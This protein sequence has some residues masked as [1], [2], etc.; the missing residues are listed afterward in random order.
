MFCPYFVLMVTQRQP[1]E[2]TDASLRAAGCQ[3]SSASPHL[4]GGICGFP[5]E[6]NKRN[7]I[8][9]RETSGKSHHRALTE[10]AHGHWE[11]P[12]WLPC[13]LGSR[14]T[15]GMVL[16]GSS[17]EQ[18]GNLQFMFCSEALISH[19]DQLCGNENKRR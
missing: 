6:G 16:E 10:K 1:E 4:F 13:S 15:E 7:I 18:G 12:T 17:T 9:L 3:L 19:S 14:E 5:G 11:V 2:G 8:T